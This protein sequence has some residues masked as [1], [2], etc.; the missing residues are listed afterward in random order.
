M[1]AIAIKPGTPEVHFVDRPEPDIQQ[2]TDI[3]MKMLQV[4]I[5]GTDREE[6]AGG[7]ADPPAGSDELVIGHEMFGQVL[8]TGS[9]VTRVKP[10]DYAV[11]TV[12]RGCG[13]CA[14]CQQNRSDM[15]YTGKYTERGI[16]GRDGY[17]A[18]YV[19][20]AEQYVVKVPE[21]I[22]SIGVLTEPMSVAAKAI[23][24]ALQIQAAR[25]KGL[26]DTGNW[27]KGKRA[28]VAGLGPIGLLA[29][30]ALRLHGAEVLGLDIVPEDNLRAQLLRDIGGRYLNGKDIK[31]TDIDQQVGPVDF[32]FEA[33]GIP[34]L[35]IQLIDTLAP[36]G[37]YVATGI[38]SDERPLTIAGGA[39]MQQ[40][41][42]NNQVIVGSVNA[43][44]QHFAQAVDYLLESRK[45]WP[46]AIEQVI[47][48][49]LPV[50]RLK[51]ALHR[52]DANEIKVV[53]DWTE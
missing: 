8:A 18:E 39:L 42:L 11:F 35:Q 19:V 26:V 29:A 16:K 46:D 14:P 49:R 40:L 9:A 37:I 34:Q 24:E 31:V 4:G 10:G 5:C 28:L 47:T 3:K 21:E 23:D 44:M 22:R 7:R 15:C 2:E 17:Q 13:Q 48:E 51:E 45:K 52:H 12:R 25:L 27:L 30:F 36:N 1:R 20:D 43:S 50:E 6:A 53:I 41:V 32:A 33:A 38:P